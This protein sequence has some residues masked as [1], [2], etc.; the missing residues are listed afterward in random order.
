MTGYSMHINGG[1]KSIISGQMNRYMYLQ[2]LT[3]F[4]SSLQDK[5][6]GLYEVRASIEHKEEPYWLQYTMNE[7]LIDESTVQH[8]EPVI[9]NSDKTKETESLAEF[10]FMNDVKPVVIIHFRS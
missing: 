7:V 5:P 8:G 9:I 6:R 2:S 4:I 10:D 1:F 3:W